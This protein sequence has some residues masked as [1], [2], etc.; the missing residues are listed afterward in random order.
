MNLKKVAVVVALVSCAGVVGAAVTAPLIN[1]PR[2]ATSGL[3]L[4]RVNISPALALPAV[5]PSPLNDQLRLQA[6][7]L[8]QA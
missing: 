4:Q 3:H 2:M 6:L 7:I 5:R 1:L 8:S